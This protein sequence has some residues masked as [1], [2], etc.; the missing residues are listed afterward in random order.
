MQSDTYIISN[1]I[2]KKNKNKNMKMK[3][4]HKKKS[5]CGMLLHKNCLR[6]SEDVITFCSKLYIERSSNFM[7][8]YK[9]SLSWRYLKQKFFILLKNWSNQFLDSQ[10]NIFNFFVVVIIVVSFLFVC[11]VCNKPFWYSIN[12]INFFIFFIFTY[13]INKT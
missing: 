3:Q 2:V 8:L 1:M 4:Q 7:F 11:F 13:Y 6:T 10:H 12:D 5:R 9:S